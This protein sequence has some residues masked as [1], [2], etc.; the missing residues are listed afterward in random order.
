MQIDESGPE[1]VG[2]WFDALELVIPTIRSTAGILIPGNRLK[3]TGSWHMTAVIHE[4][5]HTT[6]PD[7]MRQAVRRVCSNRGA[8]PPRLRG[9][10]ASS[11]DT[12]REMS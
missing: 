2:A 10:I 7:H 4:A 8:P 3:G 9:I 11:K 5:G 1:A 12:A 6:V